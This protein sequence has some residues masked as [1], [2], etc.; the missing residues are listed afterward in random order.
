MPTQTPFSPIQWRSFLLFLVSVTFLFSACQKET[1]QQTNVEQAPTEAPTVTD[2]ELRELVLAQVFGIPAAK[3]EHPKMQQL[4]ATFIDNLS[5]EE[6]RIL[7]TKIQ[8]LKKHNC[9]L[10]L[11]VKEAHRLL[12]RFQ[13]QVAFNL[14]KV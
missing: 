2:V 11:V 14:D 3:M 12:K 10:T 7:P 13:L 6:Q 1:L 8:A 9:Q 4:A 5:S